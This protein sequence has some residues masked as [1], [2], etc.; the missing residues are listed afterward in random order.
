[1]QAKKRKMLYVVGYDR[2]GG[3]VAKTNRVA[4]R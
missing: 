4:K 3:F 1:M 2:Y